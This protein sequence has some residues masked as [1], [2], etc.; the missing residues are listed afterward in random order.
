MNANGIAMDWNWKGCIIAFFMLI[1]H[2]LVS[3]I[4]YINN[5]MKR[6]GNIILKCVELVF[7]LII[8]T[9]FSPVILCIDWYILATTYSTLSFEEATYKLFVEWKE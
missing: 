1:P 7:L 5:L 9:I 4:A 3:P 2:L 6:E 8:C